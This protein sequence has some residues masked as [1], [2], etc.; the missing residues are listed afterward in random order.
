MI[1]KYSQPFIGES[2]LNMLFGPWF[3]ETVAKSLEIKI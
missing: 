1:K 3:E 2:N